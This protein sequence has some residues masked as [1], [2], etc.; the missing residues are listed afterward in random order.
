MPHHTAHFGQL[1]LIGRLSLWFAL[2]AFVG[3]VALMMMAAPPSG[4]YLEA[5][6]NM[7]Q[8]RRQ[9]PMLMTLGGLALAVGTGLSTWLMVLYSSH[10]VAGPLYRFCI[11]L[12]AGIETGQ[13]PRIRLRSTDY[14]QD[15]AR[16]LEDSVDALYQHYDQMALALEASALHLRLG[17]DAT[18]CPGERVHGLIDAVRL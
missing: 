3:L 11:D 12:E 9:L 18:V 14:V 10:R 16:H 7:S 5:L 4:D 6:R 13:V 2:L 15:E 8:T 1:R 17:R